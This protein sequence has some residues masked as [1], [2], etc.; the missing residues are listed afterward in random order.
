MWMR[1]RK[2]GGSQHRLLLEGPA[3][4]SRLVKVSPVSHG[5]G[6]LHTEDMWAPITQVL[7]HP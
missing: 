3:P 6:G 2:P 1:R 5:Y 7:T 4:P